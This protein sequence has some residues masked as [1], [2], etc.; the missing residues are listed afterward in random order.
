MIKKV[1]SIL[2]LAITLGATGKAEDQRGSP[3][4]LELPAIFSDHM[5]LQRDLPV[6]IWGKARPAVVVTVKFKNQE[7]HATVGKD[8][9]WSVHL[10]PM[11][12]HAVAG[13]DLVVT[14]GNPATETKTVR[15]VLVGDVWFC[16]GQ[17]NMR[18]PVHQSLNAS[19]EIQHADCPLIRLF[20]VPQKTALVPQEDCAGSWNV[21]SP[22]TVGE[23]SAVGYFFG[24]RLADELK[25]PIGLIKSSWGG[26]ACQPWTP[27]DWVVKGEP[28]LTPRIKAVLMAQTN[29]SAYEEQYKAAVRRHD[30]DMVKMCEL[31]ASR[32]P[33]EEKAEVDYDSSRWKTMVLPAYW[34]TAGLPD[35]DGAVWFRKTVELPEA[36]AGKDLALNL[37]PIDEIDQTWFNGE[38]V[39]E[40]GSVSKKIVGCYGIKRNYTVPGKLV[41]P[42]KNAITILVFD[43]YGAGGI[44]GGGGKDRAMTLVPSGPD[45][46]PISLAGEWRYEVALRIAAMPDDPLDAGIPGAIYNG[47]VA[48][49]IP[50]PI[51]GVIWY[52]GETDVYEYYRYE[53]QLKT[54][55]DGWRAKW[56][57]GDFPFYIVQLPNFS[58]TDRTKP[59][60]GGKLAELRNIQMNVSD[61][62]PPA[63]L[64]VTIDLGEA[65]N[66]HPLNKQDVGQRLAACALA[67]TYGKGGIYS[68][69]RYKSHA[70]VGKTIRICYEHVGGGLM[71]GRKAG[72]GKVRE[73]KNAKIEEFAICDQNGKWR[74]A[75]AVIEGDQ[76]VVSHPDVTAP[77]AVRYA[78]SSNP[79]KA[80]LY[81]KEGFPAAPFKTDALEITE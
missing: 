8:G 13:E 76:V 39:G 23:F 80:N 64:V 12:V 44:W 30:E 40:M 70:V 46:R 51:K 63:G 65:E 54:L 32:K 71:V 60:G 34:E 19:N 24:R 74:W 45:T 67:K 36:W 66:I 41:R 10:P 2:M 20:A 47:M 62:T 27:L 1:L 37:G 16:S 15:D 21:C 11:K 29:P 6:H 58:Y 49:L 9:K 4:G 56:R 81:N 59:E 53:R 7:A 43:T 5:V 79:D 50:F 75:E 33:R 78:Y 68:G 28:K 73:M 77:V 57:Q 52:Q 26:T 55:I 35:F 61:Q 17:S 22:E 31:E 38:K 69:P 72:L 14:S 25:I 3:A 42:G 48:P 18:W